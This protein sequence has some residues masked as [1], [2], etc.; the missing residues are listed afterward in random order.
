MAD[1]SIVGESAANA[2]PLPPIIREHAEELQS[3]VVQ[4]GAA[5]VCAM[6]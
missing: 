4:P 6:P 2:V 3:I 1:G 5:N